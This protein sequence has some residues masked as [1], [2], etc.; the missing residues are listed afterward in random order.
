M[1]FDLRRETAPHHEQVDAAFGALDL[2][3][4]GD[5]RTFIQAHRIAVRG[6]ERL[7]AGQSDLPATSLS[8]LLE[9]DAAAL[10]LPRDDWSPPALD[11]PLHPVGVAYVLL[12]SR[13]GNRLLQRG[14]YWAKDAPD[15]SRSDHYL[16]DRSHETAWR[17]LLD[18]LDA[19]APAEEESRR[20]MSAATATFAA[21]QQALAHAR[22]GARA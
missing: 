12:G 21:F 9:T 14:A 17:G 6:A 5:Y 10:D 16:S 20:I 11:D 4:R 1:R 18:R 7:L 13:L 3:D 2:T 22:E 19:L 8:P 15:G